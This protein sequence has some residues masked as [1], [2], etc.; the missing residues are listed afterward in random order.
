M[1]QQIHNEAI[2]HEGERT[3]FYLQRMFS[4]LYRKLERMDN[5]IAGL[6]ADEQTLAEVIPELADELGTLQSGLKTAEDARA[7]AIVD[8]EAAKAAAEAA[9]QAAA[10]D[11]TALAQAGTELATANEALATARGELTQVEQIKNGLDPLVAKATSLVPSTTPT[12]PTGDG[13][14]APVDPAA[15]TGDGSAAPA[16]PDTPVDP[17]NPDAPAAD[18]TQGSAQ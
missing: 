9:G 16:S 8:A 7:Q 14:G 12:D 13:S 6:A 5:A 18:P 11:E 2:C 17:A 10:G 3:R 4:N 15:P 1:E